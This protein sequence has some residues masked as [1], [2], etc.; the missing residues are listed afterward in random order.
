MQAP[1]WDRSPK[2]IQDF[3]YFLPYS[4]Q[5]C[6]ATEKSHPVC[7]DVN[8]LTSSLLTLAH[9]VRS[10]CK[11]ST[12]LWKALHVLCFAARKPPASLTSRMLPITLN[13]SGFLRSR[14]IIRNRHP[15][16]TSL[17]NNIIPFLLRLPFFTPPSIYEFHESCWKA[18]LRCALPSNP[19]TSAAEFRSSLSKAE[20]LECKAKSIFHGK[21][22]LM[23]HYIHS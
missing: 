18:G 20:D 21:N 3:F 6:V 19:E 17:I 8:V 10:C 22:W 9:Q 11:E 2:A 23:V 5:K 12:T 4:P 16:L 1:Y 14:S 7:F 13:N 15:N